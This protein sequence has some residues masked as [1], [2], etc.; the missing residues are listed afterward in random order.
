MTA[1][2]PWRRLRRPLVLLA[3]GAAAVVGVT[4]LAGLGRPH[5]DG[6]PVASDFVEI[7]SVPVAD[8]ASATG[9]DGSTGTAVSACGRDE[10]GH[11]NGD[12]LITMA[13]QPAGAHHTHDYVGNLSTN[14]NSTD[15][16]LAAAPTTCANGDRSSYYWPVL[17]LVGDGSGHGPPLLPASVLVQYRGNPYSKVVPMPRFLRIITG[18]AEAL[19]SNPPRPTRTAW[20]CSGRTDRRTV[21][22]PMCPAGSQVIRVFDFPSCWNGRSTDSATH[23]MHMVFPAANGVCGHGMFPIPQLHIEVAYDVPVGVRYAVDSFPAQ[24]HSPRTDH[25]GFVN[26]MTDAQMAAVVA[27]LNSGRHC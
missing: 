8:A 21:R 17:R 10:Q 14:A 2:V 19:T 24:R 22:Y 4:A 18:D 9:P 3:V 7:D 16:S 13:G 5:A 25:A 11:R 26:V 20:T 27:C 23:R 12:N 1:R 15:R 6:G